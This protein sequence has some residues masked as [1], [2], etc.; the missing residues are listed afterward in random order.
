[1]GTATSY[2]LN[3]K[4]L[5]ALQVKIS[6]LPAG[7]VESD[8]EMC[9][10]SKWE[11]HHAGAFEFSAQSLNDIIANFNATPES[12]PVYFGHPNHELGLPCPAAGWVKAL[13][14][15]PSSKGLSLW[16]RVEWTAE[17]AASIK[18]GEYRYCSVVVDFAPVNRKTGKSAGAAMMYEL[19]LVGSPFMP[20][21]QSISLS[22]V[23]TNQRKLSMKKT[24]KVAPVERTPEELAAEKAKADEAKLAQDPGQ[25]PMVPE[26]ETAEADTA[27]VEVEVEAPGVADEETM[28]SCKELADMLVVASGLDL[29]TLLKA[30]NDNLEPVVT[31]INSSKLVLP[32]AVPSDAAAMAC[33]PVKKLDEVSLSA[34]VQRAQ[35]LA[36]EVASL[37]AQVVELSAYKTAQL[38][39]ETSARIE[40]KF[41]ELVAEGKVTLSQKPTFVKACSANEASAIEIYDNLLVIKPPQG[42][43]V[44]GLSA[45]PVKAPGVVSLDGP[46][47]DT[48]EVELLRLS[49]R[50]QGLKGVH[51]D[52]FVKRALISKAKHDV[53]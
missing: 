30:V 45:S 24:D 48:K 20:G 39:V 53:A 7:S 18:K 35:V 5:F 42:S 26:A 17:T 19:G 41:S 21:M 43:L 52:N 11:G 6:L 23:E 32:E 46:L 8:V 29:P 28:A 10:T 15:K 14:V 40:A 22:N 16:G 31:A 2:N 3:G 37:Q 27:E 36:L 1:M 25:D 50:G 33:A 4:N 49:A 51:I 13:Q 9:Y 44:T 47:P 34:H 12:L 38:V